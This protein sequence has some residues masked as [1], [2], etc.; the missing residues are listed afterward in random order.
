MSA[1]RAVLTRCLRA[2]TGATALEFALVA[3][4]FFLLLLGI[5]EFGRVMWTQS[6]LHFAVEEAARC[7]SVDATN[8]GS[9]SAVQ[10]YAVTRTAGLDIAPA[11]F[12]VSS[13]ACGNQV[14][15]SYPFTFVVANLFP[16]SITLSAQSCFPK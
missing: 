8:C 2:R 13:P 4:P 14:A 7:A 15:A 3:P 6:A 1:L 16:Y 5:V 11:V 12:S 9:T 10:N